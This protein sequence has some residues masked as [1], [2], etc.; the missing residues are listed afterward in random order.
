[1]PEQPSNIARRWATVLIE[2]AYSPIFRGRLTHILD[3]HVARLSRALGT[4][5]DTEGDSAADAVGEWLVASR[6]TGPDSLKGTI[7]TLGE[8]GRGQRLMTMLGSLSAGYVRATRDQLFHQ[9]EKVKNSLLK[10]VE[11]AQRSLLE[12]EA[13]FARVFASSGAGIAIMDLD[14]EV[15][16]VNPALAAMLGH[17]GEPQPKL[18]F[19]DADL[20]VLFNDCRR[21]LFSD[22]ESVRQ[23]R[24][25]SRGP[26]DRLWANVVLSLLR[27]GEGEPRYYIAVIEDVTDQRMLRDVLRRQASTDMLT[28]L[29]NRQSFVN[30]LEEVIA[31]AGPTDTMTLGYLDVDS[32]TI[33]NDGLGYAAGDAVLREVARRLGRVL[34]EAVIARIGGDEFV[35]LVEGAPD[36]SALA[37]LIDDELAEP[38]F[39]DGHGVAV[40]TSIGFVHGTGPEIDPVALLRR[41]HST[42]RRAEKGGKR[43][44]G[45]FDPVQD[46]ADRTTSARIASMPGAFENGDIRIEYRPIVRLSDGAV[47]AREA[48]LRWADLGHDEC[49]RYA[50]TLGLA[51][52]IGRWMLQEA[53]SLGEPVLVRLSP[54]QSRDPDLA[55][56]VR[57]TLRNSALGPLSLLLALDVRGMPDGEENLE[58]LHDM[59]VRVLLHEFGGGFAGLSYVDRNPLWG[60]RLSAPPSERLARQGLAGLVPLLHAAGIQVI[61]GHPADPDEHRAL[62]VD[63]VVR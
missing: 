53:C 60:V 51:S 57:R 12:S 44:W 58:V 61:A 11:D 47:V 33:V 23:E 5:N 52:R 55:A 38:V 50:E 39:I 29:P 37:E 43:Q 54:D 1:M 32:V 24:E 10:A 56:I 22:D 8:L 2:S 26:E 36:V 40:S 35:V 59:G 15:V 45:I 21:L 48:Q 3:E 16:E 18:V 14:G 9:Q 31:R 46:L 62:G 13:R 19:A 4:E 30:R 63:L 28:G 41:A 42:L 25:L 17:S 20:A 7:E 6:F 34:P 27:D 49:A